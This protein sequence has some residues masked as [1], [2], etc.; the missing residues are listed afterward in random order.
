M[1]IAGGDVEGE[2]LAVEVATALP[3]LTPV[4]AHWLPPTSRALDGYRD[5]IARTAHVG[6][7]DQVEVGVAVDSEPDAT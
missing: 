1:A 7:Q 3:V 5:D 6:D 2:R 4:P